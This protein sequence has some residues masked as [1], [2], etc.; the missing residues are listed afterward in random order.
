MSSRW[1]GSRAWGQ[2][3]AGTAPC[4]VACPQPCWLCLLCWAA[5]V[6][7]QDGGSSSK[8]ELAACPFPGLSL[9]GLRLLGVVPRRAAAGQGRAPRPCPGD[10]G[11]EG[12]EVGKRAAGPEATGCWVQPGASLDKQACSGS[13]VGCPGMWLPPRALSTDQTGLAG[14]WALGCPGHAHQEAQGRPRP[15]LQHS[16]RLRFRPGRFPSPPWDPVFGHSSG[17]SF[18]HQGPHWQAC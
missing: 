6:Q 15:Q 17:L 5:W 8:A 3:V 9:L 13:G 2:A 4:G 10:P 11:C 14:H 1:W 18:L 7:R 16:R 12:A